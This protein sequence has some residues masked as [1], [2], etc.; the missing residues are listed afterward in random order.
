[1]RTVY[2]NLHAAMSDRGVSVS[3]IAKLIDKSEEI[4]NLKLIG[5]REWTL[6]EAVAICRYLQCPDLRNLFLR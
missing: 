5:V 4:V 1:M 3:D 6:L 2:P